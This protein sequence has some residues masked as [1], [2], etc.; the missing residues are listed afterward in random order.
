MKTLGIK[1]KEAVYGMSYANLILYS[2]AL[3]SYETT[4]K[5]GGKRIDA[6]DPGN[7]RKAKAL[8]EN[9]NRI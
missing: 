2:S 3:P 8:I 6:T 4:T 5:E 1:P 9:I 7:E